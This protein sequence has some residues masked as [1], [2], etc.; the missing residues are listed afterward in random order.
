MLQDFCIEK[1]EKVL[2]IDHIASCLA[3]DVKSLFRY[4]LRT[5]TAHRLNVTSPSS[6]TA[7]RN[8]AI[9][10]R[11][12]A[13]GFGKHWCCFNL[14]LASSESLCFRYVVLVAVV[15]VLHAITIACPLS[16]LP[17]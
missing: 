9:F 1:Q 3:L 4:D 14:G 12:P 5:R 10:T 16:I 2:L 13:T 7:V 15:Y 17:I 8:H 11:R 6:S